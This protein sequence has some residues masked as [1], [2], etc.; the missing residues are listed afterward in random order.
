[1]R[2]LFSPEYF[3]FS[4][5][6]S[7][8]PSSASSVIWKGANVARFSPA[9]SRGAWILHFA[10]CF[11]RKHAADSPNKEHFHVG[12][13]RHIPADLELGRLYVK[14]LRSICSRLNLS[15]TGGRAALIKRLDEARQNTGNLPGTPPP[16]QLSRWRRAHSEP[17][18]YGTAVPT[19]PAS[20]P[21]ATGSGIATR[22]AFVR[23]TTDSSTIHRTRVFKR[24]D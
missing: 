21:R 16:I 5:F 13:P 18:S 11:E 6:Y 17:K 23:H 20:S 24:G 12:R 10:W 19:T 3:L 14:D 8:I 15:T 2:H 9:Y 1:M 22:W 4:I 7:L